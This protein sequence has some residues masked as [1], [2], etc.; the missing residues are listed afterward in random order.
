VLLF[1]LTGGVLADAIYIA[2][3]TGMNG[4]PVGYE[5][6][7]SAEECVAAMAVLCPSCF[8]NTATPPTNPTLTPKGCNRDTKNNVVRF[9]NDPNGAPSD[10]KQVWCREAADDGLCN[11][12][13]SGCGGNLSEGDGDCDSDS[14]CYGDLMCGNDNCGNGRDTSGWL[15]DSTTGFDLTDDCCQLVACTDN[16]TNWAIG[17]GW[18]CAE[19]EKQGYDLADYCT[20]EA[21]ISDRN[22]GATCSRAGFVTDPNCVSVPTETPTE[23][24][25]EVPTDT[26]TEMPTEVPTDTP[27]E[28]PTE[29][30]TCE[31]GLDHRCKTCLDPL[32]ANDQCTSCNQGYELYGTECKYYTMCGW[33]GTTMVGTAARVIENIPTACECAKE[34]SA[35][36]SVSVY[37]VWNIKERTC[38]LFDSNA[39]IGP[40][41]PGNVS[42]E[43]VTYP[44]YEPTPDPT[45]MLADT[46]TDIET[47]CVFLLNT[48][49]D[50]ELECVD[51]NV[52]DGAQDGWDCCSSHGNRAKCPPNLPTMCSDPTGCGNGTSYCCSNSGCTS[53][54]GPR[55]CQ[56]NVCCA[57]L[58][59]E[60]LSCQLRSTVEDF[61]VSSPSTQGCPPVCCEALTAECLSCQIG[62]TVEKFC[63]ASPLTPGCTPDEEEEG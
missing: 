12:D 34:C 47:D 26:P 9:N 14:D 51:G 10:K 29:A 46:G 7:T 25:T 39:T 27:T 6:I 36:G 58:T 59:A 33:S 41:N 21:W 60:C 5:R 50:N 44:T 18:T 30:Y 57:A 40:S 20:K 49:N 63:D 3:E 48:E 24:P 23:M 45:S 31:T 17:A 16:P 43:I 15:A 35:H 32:T 55:V 38:S 52:C 1:L 28:M 13:N 42:G 62:L 22:C 4:C 37:W 11:G 2:A 19:Y 8:D 56:A 54:S 61:C 53:S